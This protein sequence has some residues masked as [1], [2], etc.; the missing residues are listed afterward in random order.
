MKGTIVD[1]LFTNYEYSNII[2]RKYQ[3]D[4]V[5]QNIDNDQMNLKNTI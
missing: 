5:I 4:L 3:F 1:N 2:S